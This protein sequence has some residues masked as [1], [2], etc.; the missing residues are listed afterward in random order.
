MR[1]D[2]R[3]A[4][5]LA[6]ALV[7]CSCATNK[8]PRWWLDSPERSESSAYG[9][10]IELRCLRGPGEIV[11]VSGELIAVEADSV[12][13]ARDRVVAVARSTIQRGQLVAYDAGTGGM[14]GFT[15]VGTLATA[16]H[17]WWFVVSAPVWIITGSIATA[18]R[19]REPVYSYPTFS[20]DYFARYARFP[21][22]MPKAIDRK[23]IRIKSS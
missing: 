3:W 21:G 10:W 18:A 12:Y 2:R 11:P 1:I 8:A 5:P 9:S 16:S 20:L 17:G 19:S 22:G 13:V 6:L 14:V 4:A 7:I 15:I 23:A